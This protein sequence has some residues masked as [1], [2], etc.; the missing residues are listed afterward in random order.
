MLGRCWPWSIAARLAGCGGGYSEAGSQPLPGR[1]RPAKGA[2][3]SKL[4]QR[5]A[6]TR[7]PTISFSNS[8]SLVCSVESTHDHKTCDSFRYTL[9]RRKNKIL[10]CAFGF[11][12][13]IRC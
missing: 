10:N 7:S 6:F 9:N 2:P 5:K 8:C 12:L 1:R 11:G 3:E 13:R 4:F